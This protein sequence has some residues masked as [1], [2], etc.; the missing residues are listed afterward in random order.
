MNPK[1]I[2]KTLSK[3]DKQQQ[4]KELHKSSKQY[5][6]KKYHTRKKV[7]SFKSKPSNHVQKAKKLYKVDKIT[8]SKQLAKK[9]KCSQ[10]RPIYFSA[11]P[12]RRR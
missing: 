3:Q 4:L 6:Q 7:T 12:H 5:K 10:K 11:K 9:T 1:Y 2:P 8:A